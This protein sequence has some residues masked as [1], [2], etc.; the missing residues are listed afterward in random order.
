MWRMREELR[1]ICENNSIVTV[2][3][4]PITPPPTSLFAKST[5]KN[6]S[7]DDKKYFWVA[8]KHQHCCLPL[9]FAFL[10]LYQKE[11]RLLNTEKREVFSS[12]NF[13]LS[14]GRAF[15]LW[16]S[17]AGK[18]LHFF[19]EEISDINQNSSTWLSCAGGTSFSPLTSVPD[20]PK[21]TSTWSGSDS[22]SGSQAMGCLTKGTKNSPSKS[23][24]RNS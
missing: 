11:D 6:K 24:I 8:L 12:A 13:C 1:R 18:I 10:L 2:S 9:R 21:C 14:M 3:T 7:K 19:C 4:S 23:L 15:D 22:V 20:R 17:D 16:S 5:Y